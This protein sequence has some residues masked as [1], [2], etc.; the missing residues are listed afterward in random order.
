MRQLAEGMGGDRSG[1]PEQMGWVSIND[2]LAT[3]PWT[4][5]N[6][7]NSNVHKLVYKL[8]NTLE[9]HDMDRSFIEENLNGCYRICLPPERIQ[10]ERV[11]AA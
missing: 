9:Q 6:V 1:E 10:I 7:T 2:L 4:T 11:V 8:R 3:L 5:P